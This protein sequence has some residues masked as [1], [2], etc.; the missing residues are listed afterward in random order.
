MF[1]EENLTPHE[2]NLKDIKKIFDV[3]ISPSNTQIRIVLNYLKEAFPQE[4]LAD[5]SINE[6]GRSISLPEHLESN[7]KDLILSDESLPTNI[8]RY[9]S[10][11]TVFNIISN[12]TIRMNC[13]VGMNDSSEVNF[14]GKTFYGPEY[15]NRIPD[16]KE[17][18]N[19]IYILSCSSIEMKDDLTQWRLYADDAKGVCLIFEVNKPQY[20]YDVRK[21]TY[22]DPE[23]ENDS[24]FGKIK[25]LVSKNNIIFKNFHTWCHFL[26]PK[27]YEIEAEVRV[28][29]E[30]KKIKKPHW[31]LAK[32]INVLSSYIDVELNDDFP[33]KLKEIILGPKC[34]EKE[35]NR[36]QLNVLLKRMGFN[37]VKVDFSRIDN[38]R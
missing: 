23:Q 18:I 19:D 12:K 38:Y 20:R 21:I 7:I 33:L 22:I 16:E 37:D 24:F 4:N 3:Y 32:P 35:T 9:V 25:E 28:L 31:F 13:I 8:C 30:N 14:V 27:D 15:L 36:D 1:D 6:D 34:P 10:L 29:Y 5:E 2:H 17:K 11:E 26:K